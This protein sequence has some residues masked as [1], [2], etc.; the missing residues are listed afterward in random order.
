MIRGTHILWVLGCVL[1]LTTVGLTWCELGSAPSE[2]FVAWAKN[3]AIAIKTVEAGHGFDDLQPLKP[4]IGQARL[5]GMGEA[6]HVTREFFQFKHR[7]LEFLV[8]ELG[9]TAIA[10]EIDAVPAARI[11]DYVLGGDGDVR[12]VVHSMGYGML[13]TEEI[14]SL[15]E[16]IR[17]HNLNAAT[18]RKVKFYGFDVHGMKP[19]MREAA[20]YL[21]SVDSRQAQEFELLAAHA[22]DLTRAK[23][24]D[25]SRHDEA[26]A[27]IQR[28]IRALET[29]RVRLAQMSGDPEW[30]RVEHDARVALQAAS[31]VGDGGWFRERCMAQNVQWILEQEGSAGRIMLWAHNL[32]VAHPAGWL[33]DWLPAVAGGYSTMGWH[34][35]KQFGP[36]YIAFG[37]S[38]NE[39]EVKST[40]LKTAMVR[41]AD[42]ESL[43]G[44]LARVGPPLFALDVRG[45]ED[46]PAAARWLRARHTMR[47]VGQWRDPGESVELYVGDCFDAVVFF[48]NTTPTRLMPL[49]R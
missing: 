35:H 20:R 38:F 32:H 13:N 5:V 31:L 22:P 42:R 3:H 36:D 4:I 7:M 6:T 1:V 19:T 48:E 11:N 28:L 24:E 40:P 8:S 26:K 12:A 10:M 21:A 27:T 34:L 45:A 16:W 47:D 23:G 9:F 14:V 33:N 30:R 43:E 39:G 2:P 15:V 41:P 17:Q 46:G 44:V 18:A 49:R 37:L 25:Q 29:N